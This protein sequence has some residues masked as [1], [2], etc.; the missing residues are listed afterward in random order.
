MTLA[1]G[2]ASALHFIGSGPEGGSAPRSAMNIRAA[3][4]GASVPSAATPD[5]LRPNRLAGRAGAPASAG[6]L[7]GL[8]SAILAR[9]PHESLQVIIVS[10]ADRDAN[11]NSVTLWQRA[12]V[13]A[14][15]TAFGTPITGRNGEN[16]WTTTHHEG[17][18]RSPIGVFS[19]TAA[20][21][22]L[23]DPGTGL[24]YEYRPSYYRTAAPQGL[25]LADA[26]N[27]VVAIDYNRLPGH[28][29]SDPT[30]PLGDDVGGDIW[31]HVDHRTPTRGCV[32]VQQDALASIM[33]W[34]A[35]TSHPMIVMGDAPDLDLET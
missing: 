22:R 32:A 31:L 11:T 20:G 8:G 30:R 1:V 27:Y 26:F 2:A 3:S 5:R 17:D 7:P 10:G 28:P 4:T 25:P 29:P 34:L 6:A 9:I 19:L 35:P 33:R 13:D 14:L 18:L 15:W 21:G 24:P 16:G 12:N 23:P